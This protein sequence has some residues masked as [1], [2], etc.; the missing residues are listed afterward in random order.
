MNLFLKLCFLFFIGSVSGWIVELL[1]RRF[2][3][4]ANPERKWINPGFCVGPYLPL[5]GVGLCLLYLIATAGERILPT[6]GTRYRLVIVCLMGVAM[7]GVEYL[8][9]VLALKIL[10]VRLWDYSGSPGN[11]QGIICPKFSAVWLAVSAVYYRGIH[12]HI[13]GALQWLSEN[14]AFSFV[15]GLFFG[16][17]TVDVVYSTRIVV[18]LKQFAEE[19]NVVVKVEN[20]KANIRHYHEE[21]KQRYHF[22]RPYDSDKP[23]AE[24]LANMREYFETRIKSDRNATKEK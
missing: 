14:L 7:T 11:I 20:I 19:Y 22:F 4:S 21:T 5:Y 1:F 17:F 10:K 18:K 13:L 9:G 16:F 12:P 8:S 2:L 23:L 15:I 3:S 24:H 6:G